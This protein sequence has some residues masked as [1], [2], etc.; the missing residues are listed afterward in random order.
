MRKTIFW[1]AGMLGQDALDFWIKHQICP[2]FFGDNNKKLWGK[3]IGNV[4]VL[5]PQEIYS[6]NK[7]KI[8][9]T[10]QFYD[11]ILN[12]LL[13]NGVPKENIVRADDIYSTEMLLEIGDALNV[14]VKKNTNFVSEKGCLIDLSKGMVLGG[15][16][17]WS[18]TL[19]K[20]L[21]IADFEGAYMLPGY[22]QNT[23]VDDTL[24]V[25]T[26]YAD[27]K[28]MFDL[29]IE[30]ILQSGYKNIICNFPHTFFKAACMI[31]KKKLS[32]LY[33][34]AVIHNDEDI[35]YDTY[36]AWSKYIDVCL[37]ISKKMKDTLLE[38]GFPPEK[39]KKL[40]WKIPDEIV[41]KRNYSI[42]GE[43]IR[44]GYAGRV[45]RIQKRV[46]LIV[47][48]AEKLKE[49]E[50]DFKIQIAGIGDYTET[51][52]K[53]IT[54]RGLSER[55]CLEGLVENKDIW[56][57][58]SKQDI[59]LNCSEWEGHS[60]SQCEAMAAGVV[61]VVTKTSGTED[62]ILDG[63]NGYLVDLHDVDTMADRIGI[64]YR[65]RRKLEI[66]GSRCQKVII[67]RNESVDEIAY[68]RGL[69]T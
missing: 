9:I 69:L 66:M 16:E 44:I 46:D 19:A 34:I 24:P 67:E 3:E 57:F 65:D 40:Y 51:L 29:Y 58:W 2:D 15:V 48:V 45:T 37:V 53:E 50:I 59:F 60:I 30:N 47:D 33:I 61:P 12:Q 10:C 6:L 36:C 23:V 7:I 42:G 5:S 25:I 41:L 11:E 13:D 26:I 38:R 14:E 22:Y 64:L 18:Y 56:K 35:Y 27:E 54:K 68:W 28:D 21:K 1:G 4:K 32:K 17:K 20:R 43:P 62:D 49:K 52:K 55:V 39:I 8:F 63:Y 31:K